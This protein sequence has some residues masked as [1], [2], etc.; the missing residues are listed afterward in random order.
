MALTR[1]ATGHTAPRKPAKTTTVSITKKKPGAG[2][3]KANT[4]KPRTK[5]DTASKV[6]GGRV[7]KRGRPAKAEKVEILGEGEK[8]ELVKQK[9]KPTVKDKVDGALEKV[10]GAVERK[11]GK[12]VRNSSFS[13]FTGHG[14][15]CLGWSRDEAT[16][17]RVRG[18][19]ADTGVEQATGTKKMR[20]TDGKGSTKA[21]KV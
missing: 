1:H 20:G 14:D 2:R 9:R 19:R 11:P 21:K 12:K 10:V 7:E 13:L 6:K 5:V 4:S 16:L 17:K 18:T 8:T 3:P 15:R